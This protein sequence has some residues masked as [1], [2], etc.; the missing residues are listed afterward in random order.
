MALN[1]AYR[2][3]PDLQGPISPNDQNRYVVANGQYINVAKAK[4]E[5]QTF[6][7]NYPGWDPFTNPGTQIQNASLVQTSLT[8]SGSSYTYDQNGNTITDPSGKTY[9]YD[10]LNHL[11]HVTGSGL[12]VSYIYDGD[13]LRVSKI[14]NLSG[15]RT[16]FLWD[17]N[18]LTHIP[19]V[20]EELQNGQVVRVYVYG[21][22]GVLYMRQL[23]NGEWKYAYYIR[24]G[25]GSVRMITD[26]KCSSDR[27][28]RLRCFRN[29]I[30]SNRDYTQSNDV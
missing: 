30:E 23:I 21:P 19:Q 5:L 25:Q 28:L 8:S 3:I 24:D 7:A 18:N 22:Q 17:R 6:R 26:G 4:Q 20:S 13:G 10:A 15:V 2:R 1:P 27:P 14:N 11:I 29:S 16:N 12:D 9:E